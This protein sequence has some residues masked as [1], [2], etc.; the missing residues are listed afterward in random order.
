[1]KEVGNE[2]VDSVAIDDKLNGAIELVCVAVD[3]TVEARVVEVRLVEARFV[4]RLGKG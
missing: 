1:M 2:N 3:R 4:C